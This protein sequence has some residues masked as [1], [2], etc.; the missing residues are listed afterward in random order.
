MGFF[1]TLPMDLLLLSSCGEI[2][3][4]DIELSID[5]KVLTFSVAS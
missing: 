5:P 2:E 4:L 3:M 1:S